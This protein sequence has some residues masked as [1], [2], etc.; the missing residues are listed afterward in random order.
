MVTDHPLKLVEGHKAV[1]IID[2]HIRTILG[3]HV[4]SVK[5]AWLPGT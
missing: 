2:L 3:G 1:I 5:R 4:V